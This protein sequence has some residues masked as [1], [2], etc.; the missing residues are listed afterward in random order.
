MLIKAGLPLPQIMDVVTGAVGNRII[1]QALREVKGKLVQGQGLS[2]P[3]AACPVFPH[4]LVQ[5]VIVGE[6]AGTLDTT[7]STM[8]DF[9]EREVE[10][11]IHALISMIEPSLTIVVGLVV[12]FIAISM[13]TPLYSMLKSMY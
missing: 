5:M 11:R 10:Q 6:K 12:A 1:R 2:Q 4:L 8:A 7:L 3:M 13:I 9:Y